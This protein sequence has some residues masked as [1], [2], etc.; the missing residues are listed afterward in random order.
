MG[1]RFLVI[2]LVLFATAC[3]GGGETPDTG[4]TTDAGG[5]G[6]GPVANACPADGCEVEILDITAAGDELEIAWEANFVPDFSRNHI[7]VFWDTFTAAEVSS[8]AEAN[9]LTQ[10]IWHPTDAYPT[11][12]TESEASVVNRGDSTTLC[13][14]AADRD[15]VVLDPS[16]VD[17]QDVADL[18]PT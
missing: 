6:D 12:V 9:G 5:T 1:R 3:G 18:L 4:G 15:H 16:R 2:A 7:H 13:V 10:G 17:C 14:T 11:Y 8:D